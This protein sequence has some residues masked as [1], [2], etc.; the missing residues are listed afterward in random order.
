M[1]AR[2]RFGYQPALDG[3]RAV[4]VLLVLLFHAGFGWMSGGYVGVSVFFTLSGFLI[5][6]LAVR[7]HAA[8]GRLDVPAFYA[9]RLRRLLPASV[10]CVAGVVV[11]AT[12]GAFDGA[13]GL[14]R[15]V[16]AALAQVY[17]WVALARDGSY[18]EVVGGGARFAPLDHYWSLAIE[19]QFYWLW[20]VVLLAVLRVTRPCRALL[21]GGLTLA[22]AVAAPVIASTW[23]PDAAYWATP[24][25][26]AEILVGATT[27]F[28]LDQRRAPRR[29]LPREVRWM[30][31]I[32]L[33]TIVVVA[34]TWP[35]DGGPADGGWLPVFALASAAL[36]VSL[37]V[38]G[39]VRRLL[40]QPALVS[41]GVVSYGVYLY[42]WPVYGILDEQRIG[43]GE[44]PLFLLRFTVTVAL[45]VASYLWIEEPIRMRRWRFARSMAGALTI[46]VPVALVALVL[47]IER[48]GFWVGSTD[49]REAAAIDRGPPDASLVV[50]GTRV[51]PTTEPAPATSIETVSADTATPPTDAVATTEAAAPTTDVAGTT[52]A[53]TS[54]VTAV[55]IA[56]TTTTVPPAT[57]T[58]AAPALPD[59]LS[60]PARIL[61]VGDSTASAVGEGLVRFANRHPELAQVSILWS[62]ACGF[63]RSGEE[64]GDVDDQWAPRCDELRAALPGTVEQL[65]PDVVVL[66]QTV[67]DGSVRT[68]DDGRPAMGPGDAG[69]DDFL[70][71]EYESQLFDL[72]AAG[73][74]R[75]AW[76]VPPPQMRVDGGALVPGSQPAVRRAIETV[77]ARHP[78]L[79]TVVDVDAWQAAQPGDLRPDGLHYSADG[80]GRLADELLGPA[81]IELAVS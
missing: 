79:V 13:E 60:R 29:R 16:V 10:V 2:A 69:F 17:N 78:D 54:P 44:W 42:H 64:I 35:A 73:A 22:A 30:A 62:P 52:A 66:M 55:A 53:S 23:G 32:A 77:A 1:N 50:T 76:L 59:T 51:V 12:L 21:V 4:A 14:R 11:A 58:V 45:A 74:T 48:P 20:P 36:I 27:A 81:L 38:D 75:I 3:V 24:A 28:V 33:A 63:V 41:L 80:A 39:P 49:A 9:R 47:P 40:A 72:V 37:Q 43:W 6:T 68:F 7:E 26:L 56:A 5:T 71:G 61:V 31:P 34:T 18:A 19:E 67:A 70:A 25:R 46:T 8:T 65:Q 15:D 57:S